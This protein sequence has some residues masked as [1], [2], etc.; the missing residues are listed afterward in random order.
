MTP[1]TDIDEPKGV[2]D[3][4]GAQLDALERQAETLDTTPEQE[5]QQ[6]EQA[7]Q[8]VS[9]AE[10]AKAAADMTVG[11]L[12]ALVDVLAPYA[13]VDNST[14]KQ[15]V[16]K[17]APLFEKYG[18]ALGGAGRFAQEIDAAI[19]FGMTGYTVWQQVEA[20]K[21]EQTKEGAPSGEQPEHVAA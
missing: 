12:G 20:H 14:K 10:G 7:E 18:I 8:A 21:A 9:L 6:Q 2:V 4:T 15:A 13:A 17:L 11:I 3:D 1:K 19:F 16:D 5:A